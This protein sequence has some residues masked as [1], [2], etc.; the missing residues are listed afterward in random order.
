MK[1]FLMGF[2]ALWI[3][4][5]TS[6]AESK[7]VINEVLPS[8]GQTS[9]DENWGS[10]DWLELYNPQNVS[11]NLKGWKIY[12]K[13]KIS[14]AWAFPDTIIGPKSFLRIFCSGN[15]RTSS[16]YTI[17]KAS[18]TGVSHHS[19]VD[20]FRFDYMQ[21]S[22]NF[23]LTLDI[24]SMR[25]V[26]PFQAHCGLMIRDSLVQFSKYAE[27]LLFN[28]NR[29]FYA[30]LCYLGLYKDSA[31]L[32]PKILFPAINGNVD[33][34][35]MKISREGDTVR[36]SC[37]DD[38]HYTIAENSIYYPTKDTIY[39]G[40]ASS[41]RNNN[42][43]GVFA[44]NNMTLNGNPVDIYGLKSW[45]V[46]CKYPGT[47]YP[48]HELHTNFSLSKDGEAVYLW[49]PDG[50]LADSL[51][52]GS[53]QHDIS[54]G[55]FPD[56]AAT[57]S[58]FQTPTEEA[59]NIGGV[60]K[61]LAAP[62]FDNDGGWYQD[63]V[64]V[65][66]T[67]KDNAKIYYNINCSNLN[68]S[69]SIIYTQP[70]K[71]AQNTVI[72]AKCVDPA[73]ITSPI[74][75]RTF[76]INQKSTLPVMSVI[77]DSNDLY[78]LDYGMLIHVFDDIEIPG[79]FEYYGVDKKLNYEA[80]CAME[81]HGNSVS[82]LN[83]FEKSLKLSAKEKYG[84]GKFEY[85][86]FGGNSLENYNNI[87][88]R[89][90]GNDWGG[91]MMRDAFCCMLTRRLN[92]VSA[93]ASQPVLIYFNG[94]FYGLGYIREHT[95]EKYISGKF[96]VSEESVSIIKNE[97]KI[98][99]GSISTFN[100]LI[101][102]LKA[103]NDTANI[104]DIIDKVINVKEFDDYIIAENYCANYDWIYNNIKQFKS[105]AIDNKWNWI[106]HDLDW[107]F[108]VTPET[109]PEYKTLTR[110]MNAQNDSTIKMPYLFGRMMKNDSLKRQ[111]L[112]R[113]ED[114]LNSYFKPA[115]VNQLIDS[116][117]ANIAA[118]IPVQQ[119]KYP[120]SAPNWQ[121]QI[122]A[123][124]DFATK[125]NRCLLDEYV[126]VFKLQGLKYVKVQSN[127][128][129]PFAI[130][131]NNIVVN[132]T[133]FD[134]YFFK[135]YPVD[136]QIIPPKN[137]VFAGWSDS[138]LP[139]ECILHQNLNDSL[140]TLTLT[141]IFY[142][143]VDTNVVINEI[144]YK[145]ADDY[146]C[147]DWVELY[148]PKAEGV[149][150]SNWIF[151]DSEDSHSFILPENTIIKAK[152]YLVLA[153]DSTKFYG[154]YGNLTPVV[155]NF[156]FGLGDA[157]QARLYNTAGMLIDSVSYTNKAPWPDAYGTGYSIELNDFRNDNTLA[158]SWHVSKTLK[159]TPDSE[160]SQITGIDNSNVIFETGEQIAVFP[161]PCSG[162]AVI[163]IKDLR[164]V[165]SIAV[166]TNAGS[167]IKNII[168]SQYMANSI[169]YDFSGLC[170]GAYLLVASDK[171]NRIIG[172]SK[173]IINK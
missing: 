151:K 171:N 93:S 68:D 163:R 29:K 144:M 131:L 123:M 45:E 33:A 138:L 56:G 137:K 116:M 13:N 17:I 106:L 32:Y 143:V 95:N 121:S 140:D 161:N 90:A 18:G 164:D 98:K 2:L 113:S 118:E 149:D 75:T 4:V 108:G 166:Y 36:F 69:N 82:R 46:N 147:D 54:Y 28:D 11:V 23:E 111:F 10:E 154:V 117:A 172:V 168:C 30:D 84:D 142:D 150:V 63:S 20:A 31:T 9:Y 152:S 114:V 165:N 155:G 76:F 129:V 7:I 37:L 87:L 99:Y 26:D 48:S 159:G 35:Y 16:G 162:K 134:G 153:K 103:T 120:K 132:D 169:D 96:D 49:D 21:L 74:K 105:T 89:N 97:A 127:T 67:S 15:N 25:N 50:K 79:H 125:R 81:L 47:K 115:P 170:E 24:H 34:G 136:I 148:N 167:F 145:A 57:M 107:S 128:S 52:F 5:Y 72:Q 141:A 110:L 156:S 42:L 158:T 71:V 85:P 122:N 139:A 14:K 39:A 61:V 64:T 146:D 44:F 160:N 38:E 101:S 8:N 102:T 12:D 88:L 157:D 65:A 112:L 80:N 100:N 1:K 22:G 73:Y 91:A 51:V 19:N 135:D 6:H 77:A 58:Y 55:R 109:S 60:S 92:T 119:A 27:L 124:K 126:N 173:I 78:N 53:M 43:L 83:E 59:S 133:A 94:D 86:F 70:I 41:S 130:K 66:L 3:F 104:Y 40:I 62:V